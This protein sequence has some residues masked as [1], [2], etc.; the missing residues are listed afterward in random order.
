MTMNT[1]A[2]LTS[3]MRH[4]SHHLTHAAHAHNHMQVPDH[5]HNKVRGLLVACTLVSSFLAI[6]H[7]PGSSVGVLHL[8]HD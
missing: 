4:M 2:V 7:E 1:H 5:E 3:H 6:L 8:A